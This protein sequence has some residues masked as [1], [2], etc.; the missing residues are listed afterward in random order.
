[1][2][3][4][5][6][7]KHLPPTQDPKLRAEPNP[8]VAKADSYQE[9]VSLQQA[10]FIITAIIKQLQQWVWNLSHLSKCFSL[11]NMTDHSLQSIYKDS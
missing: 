5:F 7:M 6:K 9:K 8:A 11:V 1:M 2:P 4:G 10:I 3:Q